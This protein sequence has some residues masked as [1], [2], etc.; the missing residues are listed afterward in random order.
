MGIVDDSVDGSL[1]SL[2]WTSSNPSV[3]S[4]MGFTGTMVEG[5]KVLFDEDKSSVAAEVIANELG[6]SII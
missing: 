6:T 4:I 2:I 5:N 1:E 3:V